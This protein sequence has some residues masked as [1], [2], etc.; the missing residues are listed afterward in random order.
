DLEANL[1]EELADVLDQVLI[2]SAK[3]KIDPNDLLAQS[4]HKLKAR[5]K[6]DV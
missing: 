2:L 3:F 6:Q 5:F 4:E 1:K